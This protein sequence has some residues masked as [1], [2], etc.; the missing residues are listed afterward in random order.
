MKCDSM[1]WFTL[2]CVLIAVLS[3]AASLSADKLELS[4]IYPH[5]A[6]FNSQGECGTGAVVPWAG[7]LWAVTYSPHKPGGSDDKLYE[8]DGDL[9]VTIRPESI[10]GTP[11][12]RMIHRESQQLFIGPYAIDS[13]CKVRAIG[14]DKM[15]GRPTGN[16]RH[17]TDPESK[18]YYA[19][20]EE[21]FYEVDVRTL[22]VVELYADTQ[23]AGNR[24]V[25]GLPGYHGK[26]LYSGQGRLIYANNGEGGSAARTNPDIPS[27]CLASWNGEDWEV[28]LRNQFT[29]VSGPGGIYGNENPR[30]D[31]VWSIGWDHRSL[32]LML[33]DGGKWHK[34]RLPKASHCYD[35]A[36]GWNTEWPRIRDI[37]EEDLV[38]TMHG[39][40]WRF[41]PTFCRESASGIA[42]KSTYLALVG[43]FCRWKDRMVLACDV[44]AKSEFLNTRRAKG[45]IA[46]PGQSQS[47]LRFVSPQQLNQFGPALGRGAVWL[48][49][50]VKSGQPSD[51]FLFNGFQRRGVHL[52]HKSKKAVKFTFEVDR[53]GDGVWSMLRSVILEPGGYEW[54]PLLREQ[55][56]WIRLHTDRDCKGA[57]AFFQYS[58]SDE[59]AQQPSEIWRG[60]VGPNCT[61]G[62]GGLVRARGENLRTLHFAATGPGG[63]DLGYYEMDADMQLKRVDDPQAH[64]WLKENVAVPQG[65]LKVEASSVLYIDD[66][67]NRYRLPKG[68]PSFDGAGPL[69]PERV[70]REVCTERDLFN[71]HGTFYELPARN[72]GGFAKIRPIA[73]HNRHITDYCSWRGLLI[74]SGICE[75]APKDNRH[76][77]RSNDGKCALWAGAVDDLWQLGK[78]VG[79]GGPWKDTEVKAGRCSDPYLMTGYDRKLLKLSHEAAKAVAIRVEVDIDG[80]GHFKPYRT[81]EVLG[82][83]TLEHRFDDAFSAYW[84]RVTADTDTIATAQFIYD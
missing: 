59:R 68:D 65:V 28:V 31:P 40:F 10:G 17:L 54:I 12:N 16:A 47:N 9:N 23:R 42:P 7:R 6:F 63:K 13:N 74:I 76:I 22:D 71:C 72:A 15:Y 30:T 26:G 58:N 52:T 51:P 49:D 46:A 27:G 19:T 80:N 33:L 32:I 37:G 43:D 84:V 29:E 25:A 38:M 2:I 48:D 18:I 56:Q 57:T 69:G 41:A 36:H 61:R 64:K 1:Q 4:G 53:K 3:P 55:A 73:T 70:D 82:G 8:I 45:K 83:K 75:N 11:A 78:C 39:M 81:F 79:T 50:D 66:D 21:G 34:F 24:R 5:M 35:G 14:Y 20:M 77:I 60:L 44:T 62:S 67:G